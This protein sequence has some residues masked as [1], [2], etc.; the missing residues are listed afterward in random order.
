[1]E[2]NTQ[3]VKGIRISRMNLITTIMT[4]S[5]YILLTVTV[6]HV[7][8]VIRDNN[9]DVD[10]FSTGTQMAQLFRGSS[11]FLTEQARL[12]VTTTDPSH[13]D[14]YFTEVNVNRHRENAVE[15]L[16]R[17]DLDGSASACLQSALDKS[18]A[19]V[20][21]EIYAMALVS[22]AEVLV[23]DS[24]PPEIQNAPLTSE[25]RALSPER[26]RE[27]AQE[28]VYGSDYQAAEARISD[29]VEDSLYA[30]ANTYSEHM[31]GNYEELHRAMILHQTLIGVH[32]AATIVISA[33]TLLLVVLPMRRYIK[34]IEARKPLRV[35][36]AY[37]C[38]R[39]AQAYNKMLTFI[40]AN[41]HALRHQ[42]EHD[43]LTG[44]LNRGAFNALQTSLSGHTGPLALLLVDVDK[45]KQVNDGYGHDTGDRVLKKVA[46]LLQENFRAT[47]YPA[48]IGGDEFAVIAM[49]AAPAEQDAILT[50]ITAINNILTHPAD[51]LPV[52]SLSVGCAFSEAGFSDSLFNNADA[53]LYVVKEHGRCGCCFYTPDLPPNPER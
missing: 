50:K 48:R 42:A 28:I 36:G 47:D 41:E 12:Y 4:L 19:L 38:K 24:L 13:M 46:G 30:L 49:D 40:T 27:K 25:D 45:F 11:S 21:R 23:P 10:G 16:S 43:A 33:F 32:F 35:S 9:L 1:M 8:S 37:E 3:P 20:E 51:G 22:F 44:L 34:D 17:L 18:A 26:M 39:L 6:S 7:S 29:D 14:G 5:L 31:G 52:V 2:N 53:A 15:A